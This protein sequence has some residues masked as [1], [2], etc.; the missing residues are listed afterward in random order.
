MLPSDSED[1]KKIQLLDPEGDIED[2]LGMDQA[3]YDALARRFMQL[4]PQR[5]REVFVP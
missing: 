3:S 1:Q 5:L 4:I 2:P